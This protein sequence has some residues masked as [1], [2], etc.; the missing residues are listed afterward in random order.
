MKKATKNKEK[1]TTI[2]PKKRNSRSNLKY[3]AL[4]PKHNLRSRQDEI[5]DIASYV[6]LLND[7]EKAFM[8]A[9]VEEEVN[10]NFKHKGKKL[11]RKKTDRQRVYAKNNARNRDILTKA[12]ASGKIHYLEDMYNNENDAKQA[13]E[14]SFN[15]N[16]GSGNSDDSGDNL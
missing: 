14:E 9:F 8:N 13:L 1:K 4:S 12:H 3:P 10:A 7:S 6:H 5:G 15:L 2:L 11:N 16:N